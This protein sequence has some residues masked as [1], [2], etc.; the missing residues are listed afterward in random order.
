MN[1][2]EQ[3]ATLKP[4]EILM[5][6]INLIFNLTQTIIAMYVLIKWNYFLVILLFAVTIISVFGEIRIG[7]L[8][9]NIRNRRSTLERKSWYYSFY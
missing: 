7:K 1:R 6:V 2:I 9:F 8:E 4:Y 5:S 3:D